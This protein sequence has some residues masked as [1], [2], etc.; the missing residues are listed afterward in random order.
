MALFLRAMARDLMRVGEKVQGRSLGRATLCLQS[1]AEEGWNGTGTLGSMPT[2]STELDR[3]A[4]PPDAD[5][6]SIPIMECT[7][8]LLVISPILALLVWEPFDNISRRA[9]YSLGCGRLQSSPLRGL[10][11]WTPP[12]T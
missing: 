11:R 12:A 6:S 8:G 1:S 7:I 9:D 2:D 4:Y 5:S 10:M 3:G